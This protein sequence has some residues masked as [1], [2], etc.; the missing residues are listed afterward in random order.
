VWCEYQSGHCFPIGKTEVWCWA[1]D[2]SGN[3]SKHSFTVYVKEKP[4][5]E[6]PSIHC[7]KDVVEYI[8][9]RSYDKCVKVRFD[10]PR[11][12]DNCDRYPKV[13]C[14]YE[15]G[16]CFPIGTTEVWCWAKD[17][18]GNESKCSFTVTVKQ[19]DNV[20]P[21][22]KC[23]GDMDLY[24]ECNATC[25]RMM[26]WMDAEATD[27]CD[28]SPKI[29][30]EANGKTIDKWYCFPYGSN[31]VTAYAQDK[32]GNKSSCTYIVNVKY[33]DD[34]IPPTF[35]CPKDIMKTLTG[36]NMCMK[37]PFDIPKAKDNCDKI[38]P[39]VTCQ[40]YNGIEFKD[41]DKDFCYP[42]GKTFVRCTAKDKAGNSYTCEF[43]ITVMMGGDL[44]KTNED[45]NNAGA[46]FNKDKT[47]LGEN[48]K[49]DGLE[50]TNTESTFS[51]LIA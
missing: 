27:D 47:K 13:W 30:Y 28:P 9:C 6:A 33:K 43:T 12:K 40:Y 50:S 38:D 25:M 36:Y 1:K 16:Y 41:V 11:A 35:A 48:V 22:I 7:P 23:P 44:V 8:D 34:Y 31:T 39:I 26:W 42:M 20:P 17:R 51:K 5:K 37:V 18:S 21:V 10:A 14:E 46:L 2:K 32:A 19:R 49:S 45:I 24:T 15:S 29:W 3:E 4:D